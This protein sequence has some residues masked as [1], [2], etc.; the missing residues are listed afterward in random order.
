MNRRRFLSGVLACMLA[1]GSAGSW[2]IDIV[3][4]ETK[5]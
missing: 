5:I 2:G 3:S 4:A 1:A